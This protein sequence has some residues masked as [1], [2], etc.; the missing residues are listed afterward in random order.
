M[1]LQEGGGSDGR[2]RLRQI[3]FKALAPP[4]TEFIYAENRNTRSLG[5]Q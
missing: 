1:R 2:S 3:W 5:V 4:H